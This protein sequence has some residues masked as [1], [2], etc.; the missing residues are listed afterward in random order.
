MV[1]VAAEHT[2]NVTD[3]APAVLDRQRL[4]ILPRLRRFAL[5]PGVGEAI[6]LFVTLRVAF[7][8]FGYV[9]S[10]LTELAP[11]CFHHEVY[12][13]WITRPAMNSEGTGFRLLGVW[14]KWDGCWYEK[15][16]TFG[17]EPGLSGTA[18]YPLYPLL[19]RTVE[20]VF[21]GNMTL[22]ALAVSG[23]SYIA[24]MVGLYRLVQ[25]DFDTGVAQRTVL[26]I[27]IFPVSFFFFSPFTEATFLALAVWAIYAAR[28]RQWALA[29]VM[30]LL[31]GFTRQQGALLAI[32]LGWEAFQALREQRRV[33]GG[34]ALSLWLPRIEM[35]LAIVAPVISLLVYSRYATNVAGVSPWQAQEWW[36]S[37]Y[38][39]PWEVMQA[40]WDWT[41]ERGDAVEGLNLGIL[42]IFFVLVGAGVKL[43]PLSYTLYAV[44]QLLPVSMR[45]NPTPYTSTTRYMLVLFP[46]FVVLALAGRWRRFNESWVMISVLFLGLILYAFLNNTFIA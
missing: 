13:K 7:S 33:A 38:H 45:L 44:V 2:M 31:A 41:I 1:D 15:I 24:A 22:G 26:Y 17:Y 6:W 35:A 29:A 20:P 37:S 12:T 16:A 3:Q 23:V 9:M 40:A 21:G 19:I 10:F 8:A 34:S 4:G 36:G 27:S 11:P 30:A 14:Q 39:A 25:H 5:P 18:F 32:P 43:L 28:T 46:A 42:L